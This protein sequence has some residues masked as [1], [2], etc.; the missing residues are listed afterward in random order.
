MRLRSGRCTS[1]R[2]MW[3][4]LAVVGLLAL[5]SPAPVAAQGY[6]TDRLVSSNSNECRG[7]PDCRSVAMPTVTIPAR[8]T[9][10]SRF[11]CPQDHPY[12]RAWDVGLHEHIG[13]GLAKI[14]YTSATIEGTNHADVAGQYVAYLGC[15]SSKSDGSSVLVQRRLAPTGWQNRKIPKPKKDKNDK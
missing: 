8:G 10:T 5:T 15:S 3:E 7:V 11:E 2:S 14:D 13:V 6:D 4:L 9:L 12:L 1:M